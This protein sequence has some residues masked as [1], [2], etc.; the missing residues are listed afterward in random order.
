MVR[1]SRTEA[2]SWGLAAL[3]RRAM[4]AAAAKRSDIRHAIRVTAAVG[5]SFALATAL[6]LPQGFWAVFT[7]VIVVQTSIGGTITATMDR[8]TGTVVGGLVGAVAA[9]LKALFGLDAALVLCAVTAITAFAAAGRPKLKVA[10]ITAVIV[11]IA[12]PHDLG[13]WHAAFYRVAEILVG[14]LVGVAA[15][16]FIFPAPAHRL[17]VTRLSGA[18]NK[19]AYVLELYAGILKGETHKEDVDE[20]HRELR[21]EIGKI[22]T[23][24]TE[25]QRETDSH[26]PGRHT[27]ERAPRVLW[28]VRN[29]TVTV[30]RALGTVQESPA[31]N[32]LRPSA[33]CLVEAQIKRLR[34]CAEAAE[35]HKVVERGT[36]LQHQADFEATLQLLRDERVT[37]SLSADAAAGLFGLVFA[38]SS[39]TDN[40]EDLADVVDEFSRPSAQTTPQA[41]P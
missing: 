3:S 18:M 39:L 16:L 29:D 32:R 5:V 31:L 28:R 20:A 15:T 13:P 14:G 33:I 11:V 30:E 25:A 41:V 12:T 24:V 7:A 4:A 27:P 23:A 34:N 8:L 40:L 9:Y 6:Q 22:E 35:A 1:V 17:V 2:Q 10:P 36:L 19:L 37:V 38:L 26:L 21:E